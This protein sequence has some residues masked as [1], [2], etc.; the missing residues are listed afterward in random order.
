MSDIESDVRWL[1]LEAERLADIYSV[2]AEYPAEDTRLWAI[3]DSIGEREVERKRFKRIRAAALAL[4]HR[5][6]ET[7]G[8]PGQNDPSEDANIFAE[9]D[10]LED[11]LAD[12]ETEK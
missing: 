6:K 12:K 11:A 5:W 8:E 7:R 3:A 1:R 4:H 9:W 10:D 2:D